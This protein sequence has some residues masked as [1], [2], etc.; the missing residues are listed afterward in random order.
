MATAKQISANQANAAKS[1]GPRTDSGKARSRRNSIKHGLLSKELVLNWEDEKEFSKLINALLAEH[2]PE[3][4][5]ETLLVEQ[6]AVSI[7]KMGRLTG[8]ERAVMMR[9]FEVY[10]T[11]SLNK[12]ETSAEKFYY[13][14]SHAMPTNMQALM[15]YEALLNKGFHRALATLQNLQK[16]RSEIID[17]QATA[18]AEDTVD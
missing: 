10:L 5:T 14:L 16:R 6:M 15:N 8:M 3:G 4:A 17:G 12:G 7:W 2:R 11:S 1:T 9:Q 18:I 13:A